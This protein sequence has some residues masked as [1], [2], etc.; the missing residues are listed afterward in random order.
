MFAHAISSTS[1]EIAISKCRCE[2]YSCCMASI[3]PPPGVSTTCTFASAFLLFAPRNTCL[4][5]L[6]RLPQQRAQLRLQ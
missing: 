2:A 3:P 4:A 6:E 1:P 5:V